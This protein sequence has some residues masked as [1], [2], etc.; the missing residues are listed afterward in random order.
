MN[1]VEEH[2]STADFVAGGKAAREED[3]KPGVSEG[4]A[5][6]R[7]D[8]PKPM[9]TGG[10]A[11]AREEAPGPLLAADLVQDLRNGWDHIQ[12]GFVDEPRAAVQQADELV[13]RAMKHIAESFANERNRLEQQWDRGDDVNTED[14][15]QALR[16]YRAF[17][18]RL[19]SV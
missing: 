10:Q 7:E 12:T 16:K 3:Q 17:F 4:Q 5:I 19:L 1:Q 13:A 8:D 11:A 18:Q 14:L 9:M 15:R 6:A 2:L